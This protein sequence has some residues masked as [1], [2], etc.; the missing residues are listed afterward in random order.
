[1]EH[2]PT[3]QTGI[4][5]THISLWVLMEKKKKINWGKNEEMI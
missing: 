4:S 3:F 5:I 2:R 1:M